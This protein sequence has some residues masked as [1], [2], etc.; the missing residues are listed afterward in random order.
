MLHLGI[1]P[2]ARKELNFKKREM[3]SFNGQ[4]KWCSLSAIRILYPDASDTRYRG[5]MVQ[6]GCHIAQGQW[7]MV[8]AKQ[9][10]TW[11]ELHGV[12]VVLEEAVRKLENERVQ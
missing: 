3:K 2:D 10:S 4:N 6:H 9:C 11:R 8:E 5:Y 12:R 1:Y 7:S